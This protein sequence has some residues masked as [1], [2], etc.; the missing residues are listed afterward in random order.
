MT[1]CLATAMAVATASTPLVGVLAPLFRDEI[2]MPPARV[3]LLVATYAAVS[4][5][6]SW[7][8][9]LITDRMGGRRALAMVFAGSALSLLG[10]ASATS[11]EWLLGAVVIAGFAN[12]MVNPATNHVIAETIDPGRRGLIAG[13]KMAGVQVAVFAVGILIPFFDSTVGWRVPLAVGGGLLCLAGMAVALWGI[14]RASQTL[15]TRRV[16][17][18]WS[19]DLIAL[20]TY[21]LLMSAGGSASLTY[22]PLY[23]V[24]QLEASAGTAGLSVAA[25]GLFAIGGRL[26]WGRATERSPIVTRPLLTIAIMAVVCS[27]LLLAAS[28]ITDVLF[29]AG[30]AGVG[31]FALGFSSA[32]TV[33]LILTVSKERTGS[34]SGVVFGGFMIGFG[35][36]PAGFGVLAESAGGYAAAWIGVTVAFTISVL[37]AMFATTWA[38]ERPY[39]ESRSTV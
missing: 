3:G 34:A 24:D 11:Y 31:F 19:R 13:V 26:F 39:S 14:Q 36:G 9:G 10:V 8:A 7:P 15:Q 17:F 29:W 28:E 32:T 37:V 12:S 1:L 4:A 2:T 38:A 18:Q 21:S 30:S 25:A 22:L 27:M 35:L 33:A 16:G 6:A 20:T 5:L 23:S